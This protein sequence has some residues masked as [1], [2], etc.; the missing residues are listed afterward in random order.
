MKTFK[1]TLRN[2][3][4]F[5]IKGNYVKINYNGQFCIY[6][7]KYLIF[8]ELIAIAPENA[9]LIIEKKTI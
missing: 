8:R 1:I 7:R 3:T 2:K 5:I 4:E 9:M 6:K